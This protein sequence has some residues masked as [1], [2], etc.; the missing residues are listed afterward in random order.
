MDG[1]KWYHISLLILLAPILL[2]MKWYK[3]WKA[4]RK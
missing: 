1:F 3:E 4:R 2:P